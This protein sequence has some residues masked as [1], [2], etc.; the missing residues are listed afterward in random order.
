MGTRQAGQPEFRIG[1]LVRDLQIL[2]AARKEA[3]FYL[4]KRAGTSETRKMIE[5]VHRDVRFGLAAVG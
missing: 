2:E 5:H 4:F 3:E 1:N